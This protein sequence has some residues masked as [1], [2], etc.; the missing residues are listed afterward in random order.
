M[1]SSFGRILGSFAREKSSV[2][3]MKRLFSK[4]YGS[5]HRIMALLKEY[6]AL[7]TESRALLIE[8]RG[9]FQRIMALFIEIWL[10]S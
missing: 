1:Q 4:N 9:S 3:C 7:L 2:D 5:F 6:W 8:C 10:F